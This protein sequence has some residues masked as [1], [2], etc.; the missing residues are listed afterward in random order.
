MSYQG[1][2]RARTELALSRCFRW[3]KSD[4]SDASEA[5]ESLAQSARGSLGIKLHQEYS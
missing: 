2:C 5:Q 1:M 4:H 3:V